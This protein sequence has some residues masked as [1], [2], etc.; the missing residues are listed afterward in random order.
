VRKVGRAFLVHSSAG[1]AYLRAAGRA[2]IGQYRRPRDAAQK[3]DGVYNGL[4]ISVVIPCFNEERGIGAVLSRMPPYVDEVIVV[5]N[6]SADGTARIAQEHGARVVHETRKG[7]GSA[8]QAGLPEA[9]GDI[10]ATLDGDGTYPASEIA[11]IVD[12][13]LARK[14]DFVS[15]S[16]FPLQ[17]REAMRRRNWLG[18]MI[19][20]WTMRALWLRW[21]RDSQSGMWVFR[22]EMLE[23][24]RLTSIGMP[25]SEEIKIEAMAQRRYRFAEYPICYEERIGESKLFPFQ[26]GLEN[27]LFLFKLRL[28]LRKNPRPL[29]R[30]RP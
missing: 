15:A 9:R 30:R 13:M 10:I 27:L 1:R 20:T 8:Y 2:I 25:F 6:N 4:S 26:N 12:W 7:Y 29:P 28:R 24:L 22:R 5:D 18:N 23:R 16:R 21:I 14:V 3:K 11:P 17:K 19:L